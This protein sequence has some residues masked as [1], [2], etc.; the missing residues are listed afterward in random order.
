TLDGDRVVDRVTAASA[1][2][3]PERRLAGGGD[4]VDR[5]DRGAGAGLHLEPFADRAGTGPQRRVEDAPDHLAAVERHAKDGGDVPAPGDVAARVVPRRG[6][7]RLLAVGLRPH[8]PR[9]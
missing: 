5:L 1:L 8:L 6:K 2:A 7:E 3:L 9:L 4:F